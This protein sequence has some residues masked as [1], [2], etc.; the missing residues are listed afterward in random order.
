MWLYIRYNRCTPCSDV[1]Y[2]Q[3]DKNKDSSET[4]MQ[5]IQYKELEVATENWN[6]S[7][8]LGEGGFGVVYKGNWRYT[9]V[10]IKRLKSDV[11]VTIFDWFLEYLI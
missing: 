6:Q 1:V 4:F 11:G 10:A 8:I 3:T 9:D 2:H 7:R 5:R